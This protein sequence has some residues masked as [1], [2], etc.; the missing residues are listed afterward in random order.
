MGEILIQIN[1][2]FP[3]SCLGG[4][5][6]TQEKM[7]REFK[8]VLFVCIFEYLTKLLLA[9]NPSNGLEAGDDGSGGFH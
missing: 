9:Q 8:Y 6:L 7:L 3:T 5:N 2:K 1:F 4:Y